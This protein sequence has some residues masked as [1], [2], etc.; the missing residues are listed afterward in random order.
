MQA[1]VQAHPDAVS[2]IDAAIMRRVRAGVVFSANSIRS[3]L[4]SLS[5]SERPCIGARMN[6]LARRHCRKVGEEPS[7]DPGTH[8]KPVTRWQSKAAA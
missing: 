3:E 1:A 7:T 2:L 4:T 8:G 5:P 6:A